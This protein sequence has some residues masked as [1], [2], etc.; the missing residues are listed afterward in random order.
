[1]PWQLDEDATPTPR[2]VE[3]MAA[4][5]EGRHGALAFDVADFFAEFN[6]RRGDVARAWAWTVVAE[7][8]RRRANARISAA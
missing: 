1:V 5:L 3:Q 2:E 6:G 4:T 8:V 7:R